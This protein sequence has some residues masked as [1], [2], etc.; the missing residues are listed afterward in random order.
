MKKIKNE[1]SIKR[2]RE[3]KIEIKKKQLDYK[4]SKMLDLRKEKLEDKKKKE[5]DRFKRKYQKLMEIELHNL[6][7][8]RKRSIPKDKTKS[9]DK[10]KALKEIQ[11]YSKL[12]RAKKTDK[13]IMVFVIDKQKRVPLDKKV[14]W[15]HCYPQSNFAQLAFDIDNIRPITSRWNKQQLDNIWEWKKY[16]PKEIQEKLEKKSKNKWLKWSMR[17]KNFYLQIIK[18]YKELNSK[19][20]K[21]LGI[22]K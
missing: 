13:W 18:T 20:E 21:R 15:W 1:Y 19:E 9:K 4:Y 7:H 3:N 6:T 14:N 12:V 11:K 22:I 2:K 17:D 5:L 8:K 16:L 10:A